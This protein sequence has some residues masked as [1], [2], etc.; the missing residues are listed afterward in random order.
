[1]YSDALMQAFTSARHSGSAQQ[2]NR[3]SRK[4]NPVCGD[5]LHLTARLRGDV[6]EEVRFQAQG[7]PPVIA[8]GSVVCQWL[9]GR[10]LAEASLLN[11][12]LVEEMLGGVPTNKRHALSLATL[13]AQ[14][15]CSIPGGAV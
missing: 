5:I 13:A 15:I 11:E 7:C 12:A 8:A 6:L 1:M 4:E 2:A 9:E 3:Q 14:E 10:N